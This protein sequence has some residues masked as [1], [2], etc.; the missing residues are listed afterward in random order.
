MTDEDLAVEQEEVQEE[1][2]SDDERAMAKLKEAI[3]VDKDEIGPLRLKLKVTVPRDLLDER[4]GE[5]FADLKR[6]ADIPG[7]RKGHAPLKLVEKR[8]AGDVGDQLKSALI[9]GGYLAAVEKEDLKVLGDPL[10]LVNVKEDRKD[11]Q[12]QSQSVETE[13]LVPFDKAIDA[14]Q[15]PKEGDLDFSFEIELKPEIDLPSLEKIPVTKPAISVGDDDVEEE[16]RRLRSVRGTFQ[17]VTKGGV[18]ADDMIYT[19]MTMKVEGHIIHTEENF[20][21][22]ARD[23]RVKGVPLSGFG[24]AVTGKKIDESFTFS[25]DVPDDHENVEI[26]GKSAEFDLTVREIKRLE[27]PEIDEDFLNGVGMESEKELRD[28]LRSSLESQLDQT[29]KRAMHE[30]IGKFLAENT[31]MD[32]PEGLSE[33]QTERSISRRGMEMRHMGVPATEVDK[34]L[35]EM[36]GEARDQVVSDLK[37]FFILE[38]IAE[39]RDIDV[40]EEELNAAIAQIAQ[41]SNKRFDRMRDELSQGEG[42]TTLYL[43]LRDQRVL[44]SLLEDA[45][46]T[47]VETP[48]TTTAEKA[49]KKTVKKTTTKTAKKAV[50]KTKK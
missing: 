6:D 13:K 34:A 49:T 23:V 9:S 2:L 30:Q 29:M 16:L 27:L 19:D 32:V 26:R 7:F 25:A 18:K 20:D 22:A 47:E 33:R 12:G 37:L 46:V 21:L 38:K 45:E 11:E 31:K 28:A 39:D 17:P 43:R 41:R 14:Y 15:M 35:D 42:M 8:F 48:K 1:E 4:Y 36:R 40:R 50:K 10:F 3:K 24:K 44:S 5:Q